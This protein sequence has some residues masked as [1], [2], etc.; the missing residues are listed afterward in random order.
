MP[1]QKVLRNPRH[2]TFLVAMSDQAAK[3]KDFGGN[4]CEEYWQSSQLRLLNYQPSKLFPEAV[5][6]LNESTDLTGYFDSDG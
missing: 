2:S 3:S 6:L 5:P 1:Q 4:L